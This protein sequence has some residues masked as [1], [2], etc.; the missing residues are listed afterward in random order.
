MKAFFVT[1]RLAFGSAVSSSEHVERLRAQGIT[2]II[3]LRW[4]RNELIESFRSLWLPYRDDLKWRPSGFYRRAL[5]FYR[6][7][8][9]S[10]ESNVFVMCHHGYRRS[11]AL[12]YFLLRSD[13][14]GPRLAMKRVKAARRSAYV[15]SSY[16]TSAEAFLTRIRSQEGLGQP[17]TEKRVSVALL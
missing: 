16:R 4:H 10:P 7:A 15:A 17:G 14:L 11:P 8:M 2:H 6:R 1:G 12:V 13:G 9:R 5:S 3:N